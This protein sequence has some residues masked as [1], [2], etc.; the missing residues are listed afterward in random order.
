MNDAL[1]K[2][3]D[4]MHYSSLPRTDAAIQKAEWYRELLLDDHTPWF[5]HED[6]RSARQMA[7]Q[8]MREIAGH[9]RLERIRMGVTAGLDSR[10]LL[11][12]A[13]DVFRPD[14]IIGFTTGQP[15]NRDLALARFFT[16]GVLPK[17]Y[18]IQTEGAL[19][20][21]Q[22][23]VSKFRTRPP[24]FVGT[25][26]GK[27]R[28]SAVPFDGFESLPTITG[29]L[30]DALS[31]KR[32]H[33][34]IHHKWDDAKAAYVKKNEIYRPASKRLFS[35]LLPDAYDPFHVLPKDPLLPLSLMGYDDQLDLCFRQH[36]RIRLN[37]KPYSEDEIAGH[38]PAR[39]LNLKTITIYDDPR[40]QKSYLKMPNEERLKQS[41]YKRMM[42]EQWPQIFRDLVDPDDP[43]WAAEPPPG[44]QQER[45]ERSARNSGHTNWE[46]LWIESENFNSF[47]RKLM[48][49]LAR[50]RILPWLDI[51]E[52]VRELDRDVLGLGKAICC[53]C[54]VELNI[55]AGR[56]PAEV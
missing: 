4:Y 49:S 18:L 31:G 53:L 27:S 42:R 33:G 11:G 19:Y 32:L 12:V 5:T 50:R 43:R 38:E 35:S 13:L 28:F 46:L 47:A 24:G 6:T 3:C 41:H 17:H 25:L 34:K 54:S 23:W 48:L 56:L 37:F 7:E 10:G 14:A 26:H 52:L 2:I 21:E 22:E 29:F 8:I 45:Y 15:G 30:G 55:R 9:R 20:E 16:T 51:E 36:Q 1:L 40:W 44:T 39:K